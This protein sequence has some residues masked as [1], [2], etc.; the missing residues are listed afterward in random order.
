MPSA[1]TL[2]PL[3]TL[4]SPRTWAPSYACINGILASIILRWV[5]AENWDFCP[6]KKGKILKKKKIMSLYCCLSV[7]WTNFDPTHGIFLYVWRACYYL[8]P[9]C[10]PIWN[11]LFSKDCVFLSLHMPFEGSHWSSH[12]LNFFRFI[13]KLT[14][15]QKWVLN[16][17]YLSLFQLMHLDQNFLMDW[18]CLFIRDTDIFSRKVFLFLIQQQKDEDRSFWVVNTWQFRE[19]KEAC[20]PSHGLA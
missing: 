14:L 2:T 17:N 1:W 8:R 16:T 3:E 9:N 4:V 20:A 10:K 13:M 12:L 19:G 7:F 5:E 6:Y 11:A 18:R 15:S